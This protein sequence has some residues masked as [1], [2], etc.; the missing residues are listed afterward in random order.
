MEKVY[1]LNE[2]KAVAKNYLDCL[3]IPVV[4]NL[5]IDADKIDFINNLYGNLAAEILNSD[6]F[7]FSANSEEDNLKNLIA[8]AAKYLAHVLDDILNHDGDHD[9]YK[10][11]AANLLNAVK[12]YAATYGAQK[13][14]D[15]I[16]QIKAETQKGANDNYAMMIDFALL[17][18]ETFYNHF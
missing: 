1:T 15:T 18:I 9:K 17:P 10:P 12:N 6:E 8:E 4:D 5:D 13:T 2:V 3:Y 14:K 11:A 16:A 7:T